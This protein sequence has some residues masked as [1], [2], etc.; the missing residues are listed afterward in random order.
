VGDSAALLIAGL[1]RDLA[2][3]SEGAAMP[4][5]GEGSA[6]EFCEARG[7]CRRDHWAEDGDA[8]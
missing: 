3:L 7:L 8:E 4:A 2:R 6:C 1:G 5:L